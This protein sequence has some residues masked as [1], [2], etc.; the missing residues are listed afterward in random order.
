[1]TR[2]PVGKRGFGSIRKLPSGRYQARYTGPDG[3][4]HK[5]P[6]TF[7]EK[8]DAEGKAKAAQ[9]AAAKYQTA[10]QKCRALRS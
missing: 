8:I 7:A 10:V 5:A 1:M 2:K 4:E 6:K 9:D 3:G